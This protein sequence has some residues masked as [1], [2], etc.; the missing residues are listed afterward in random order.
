READALQRINQALARA[1]LRADADLATVELGEPFALVLL[2]P[3][4]DDTP[5]TRP[6][7]DALK[8]AIARLRDEL[9]SGDGHSPSVR[10]RS[11]RVGRSFDM[12]ALSKVSLGHAERCLA[13]LQSGRR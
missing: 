1:G 7:P 11:I 6:P 8:R 5:A 4:A 3:A 13:L 2:R 10:L 9:V 12:A